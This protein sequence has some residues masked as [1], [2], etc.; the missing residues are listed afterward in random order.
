MLA[1]KK[2]LVLFAFPYL[3][4]EKNK[5]YVTAIKHIEPDE[6]YRI[7]ITQEFGKQN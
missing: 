4:L 7:E 2:K 1:D 6:L 5:F 3:C